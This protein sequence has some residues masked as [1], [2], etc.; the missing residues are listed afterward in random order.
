MCSTSV[1]TEWWLKNEKNRFYVAK[2]LKK[3]LPISSEA[4]WETQK[5]VQ[6]TSNECK[7]MTE[8]PLLDIILI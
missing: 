2:E 5:V 1:F 8:S 7:Q 3:S 4:K 6:V